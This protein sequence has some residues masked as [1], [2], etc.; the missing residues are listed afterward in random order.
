MKYIVLFFLLMGSVFLSA[1]T[2]EWQTETVIGRNKTEAHATFTPYPNVVKALTFDR[3]QSPWFRSLNGDWKFLFLE[4]PADVKPEYASPTFDDSG[5]DN[6]PVPSNWQVKGYGK[7]I[8]T[9]ITHPFPATPPRVPEDKNETGFY[10]RSFEIPADWA[11]KQI[12]LHFAGVQ[13]AC[14]VWV[15][16]VDIGYSEGSMTPAE[17]DITNFVQPGQNTLAV[18]VIN[19]SDGSYLEDQDFWRIS[20]IFREVV[21]Y[22][23]PTVH[24]RDFKVETTF[25]ATMENAAISLNTTIVNSGSKK[26]KKLQLEINL[27]DAENNTVFGAVIPALNSFAGY[28][29][30]V[31][32][33]GWPVSNPELWSAETPYLY[34]LTI[35]LL[36]KNGVAIE[37]VSQKV[38]FRK[39]EIKNGQLL[40]NEKPIYIKGVNRHESHPR[41]GR[42]V[43]EEAMIQDIKLMK[44]NNINSVRT[45]HYP[46]Q[47]R[48]YE[49]CD[50]Y[51]LYVFDE[52]NI[53]S[54][55]LWNM[56][57]T[58]AKQ[59]SWKEAFVDRGISMVHRDKNHPCIIVWSL[60]NETGIG[61]NH[62]SMAEAIKKIDKTRPLHYEGREPYTQANAPEFD[63]ISNMYPSAEE[64]YAL[65]EKY[66]D[67]PVILCE[68]AHSMGNSTGNLDHYWN[69]FES[70]PRLQGGFIWD[71]ADQGLIKKNDKGEEFFAYGGDFGDKPNDDNFCFNGL[72]G[73]DRLPHP[74]LYEVKKIQQFVKVSWA[75][76]EAKK[77]NVKNTYD[78]QGL[79]FLEMAWE[80]I[81]NGINIQSGKIRETNVA[82]QETREFTIPY[83]LPQ[84]ARNSDRKEYFLNI[85]FLV[86]EDL[87]WA[88]AGHELAWEQLSFPVKESASLQ[89]LDFG[90]FPRLVWEQ[91]QE[92]FTVSGSNF[93]WIIDR[94]T[95]F[96]TG[97]QQ[98][99]TNLL[100]TGPLPNVWRAFIDNDEGGEDRSFLSQ[101]RKFGIDNLKTEIDQVT[102][103]TPEEHSISVQVRGRLTGEGGEIPFELDQTFLPD[104]SVQITTTLRP[105][106][107]TPPLPKA[108]TFWKIPKEMDQVVW[109]GRG[110]HESYADRKWS[111]RIG[112]YRGSVAEQYFP[113]GR[114]QENGNKTDVR[115]VKITNR[116]GKGLL[117]SAPVGETLNFSAHHYSLENLTA[118]SHPY[119]LE[120]AGEITLNIDHLQMGVGG[121][122][123]WNPRTHEEYLLKASEY[124]W[125]YVVRVVE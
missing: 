73:P 110:P 49:L 82:P 30:E 20:G 59:P 120:D 3:S 98:G 27:Y 14:Y 40:V 47:P 125:T 58:P 15:N 60:G 53:E 4:K 106:S 39:V 9:N 114:P 65:A 89:S 91:S 124:K 81:E 90:A 66:P 51:G 12:L 42:A 95:G 67:R 112:Q 17:F 101:W 48:W 45:A 36:D 34:T 50:Q 46:N 118:A 83:S 7:P 93:Q 111:A 92:K 107:N 96:I 35:Q 23:N 69:T 61:E 86:K 113:Y 109:Y 99:A 43:P 19:W 80:L 24:I 56:Q 100:N 2:P 41:Y 85:R 122:D 25:G 71:W 6:I 1:Q 77:I 115:W 13:S 102:K 123:S 54:H 68:Y 87:P 8:Y 28:S 64:A 121:D 18:E 33:F 29:E 63:I 79:G 104:G 74:A 117:F 38:G 22:A 88:A 62:Y 94:N 44:Q 116:N 5:W 26:A 75:D 21:L 16:G 70:H 57:Q 10:R 11:D 55:M 76:R 97:W 78:F 103:T 105:G 52:A 32:S 37:A 108:G 84:Q 72:V 119:K 31:V